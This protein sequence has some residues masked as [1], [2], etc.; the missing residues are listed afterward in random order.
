MKDYT[1]VMEVCRKLVGARYDHVLVQS[2]PP[3][4]DFTSCNKGGALACKTIIR[5]NAVVSWR[6]NSSMVSSDSEC[7]RTGSNDHDPNHSTPNCTDWAVDDMELFTSELD[8]GI[9]TCTDD[10]FFQV[11]EYEDEEILVELPPPSMVTPQTFIPDGDS[12]S[13]TFR[14][15]PSLQD[16]ISR[17]IESL[18]RQL[19]AR[20]DKLELSLPHPIPGQRHDTIGW[21]LRFPGRTP[22]ESWRF[23]VLHCL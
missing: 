5:I 23:C 1:E 17:I 6:L 11:E 14:P 12:H 22:K 4:T 9:S 7:G 21:T 2:R 20:F 16:R 15:E 8:E 13:F 3:H 19:V 10:L 18:S